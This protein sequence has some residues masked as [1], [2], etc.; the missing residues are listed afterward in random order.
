MKARGGSRI[1]EKNISIKGVEKNKKRRS[2]E[3]LVVGCKVVVV[4]IIIFEMCK[5]GVV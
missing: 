2:V 5:K 1:I 3:Y 4:F